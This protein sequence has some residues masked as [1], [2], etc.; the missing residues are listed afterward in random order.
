M[1][2]KSGLFQMPAINVL[3]RSA[4]PPARVC[5]FVALVLIFLPG[6]A[7]SVGLSKSFESAIYRYSV[8][9]PDGW[10][11]DATRTA[12]TLDI[13]NF[14]ASSAVYAVHLPRGGAKITLRP[15]EAIRKREAPLTLDSWVKADSSHEDATAT[16]TFD[17]EINHKVV[18]VTE[19]CAHE[20]GEPPVFEWVDWYFQ[21]GGRRFQATVLYWRGDSRADE[22]RETLRQIVVSLKTES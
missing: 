14:P 19:V 1:T 13:D 4:K 6:S 21:I 5:L 11:I 18:P 3:T 22:L 16:R 7:D 8:E 2:A 9:Y 12:D 10:Y 20:D 17:L 15:L